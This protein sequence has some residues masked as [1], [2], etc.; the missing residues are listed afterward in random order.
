M[1]SEWNRVKYESQGRIYEKETQE[2]DIME[3][4]KKYDNPEYKND[5]WKRFFINA[6]AKVKRICYSP[7][8]IICIV[9]VISVI[10]VIA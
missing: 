2:F 6:K 3:L 4:E 5:V 7:R 1:K 10:F 9:I 8:F